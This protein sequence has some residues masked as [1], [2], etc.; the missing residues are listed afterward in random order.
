MSRV[1]E[2]TR[3]GKILM[4]RDALARAVTAGDQGMAR[5]CRVELAT[6]GVF[7]TVEPV[8]DLERVVPEKPKRGRRPKP[9]CEHN[10]IVGRCATCNEGEGA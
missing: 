5:N 8:D 6:L 9:R 2:S 1:F 10:M 7:E 4:F 3:A